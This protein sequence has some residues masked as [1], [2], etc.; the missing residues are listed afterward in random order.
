MSNAAGMYDS[1]ANEIDQ[2]SLY[3]ILAIPN[4]IE[5]L[6]DGERCHRMLAD[7][8]E[9]LLIFS[10]RRVFQPKQSIGLE[11]A[12]QPRRLNRRQSM[13]HIVQQ[14]DLRAMI[15]AQPLEEFGY[16]PQ[17]LGGR[18]NSLGRE[19]AFGRLVTVLRVRDA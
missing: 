8:L 14:L 6:A 4:R 19:G 18:P 10:R 16:G 3:Q 7:Q 9:G 13:M 5:D 1:R 17:V 15:L 11:I 12:S 2:L